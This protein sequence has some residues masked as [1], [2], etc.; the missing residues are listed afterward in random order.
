M[1]NLMISNLSSKKTSKIL[2]IKLYIFILLCVEQNVWKREY[3]K[4]V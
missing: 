4:S 3:E 1:K 2:N